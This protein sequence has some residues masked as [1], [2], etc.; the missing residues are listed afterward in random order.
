MINMKKFLILIFNFILLVVVLKLSIILIL[1]NYSYKSLTSKGDKKINFLLR[2]NLIKRISQNTEN[3][4][5]SID[6]NSNKIKKNWRK[7]I[8]KPN[9][10]ISN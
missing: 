3:G 1:I 5:I 8:K 7:N 2:N 9:Y 4:L 10:K 6:I